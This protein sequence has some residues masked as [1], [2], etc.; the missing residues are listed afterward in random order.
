MTSTTEL[1]SNFLTA[2]SQLCQRMLDELEKRDPD[3]ASSVAQAIKHGEH[4][5][6][7]FVYNRDAPAIALD[8]CSDYNTRRPVATIALPPLTS[9]DGA[10]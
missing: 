9:R 6:L 5:A 3:M 10:H 4:L 1:T 8:C 2:A 7:A